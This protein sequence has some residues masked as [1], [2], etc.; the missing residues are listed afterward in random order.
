MRDANDM[1]K[2]QLGDIVNVKKWDIDNAIVIGV[3][4][5]SS[6]P[7]KH[8]FDCVSIEEYLNNQ[9]TYQYCLLYDSGSGI[10][11]EPEKDW[12]YESIID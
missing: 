4:Q 8:P 7:S 1:Q 5:V 6:I 11:C 9:D 10:I 3:E 2:Y 12:Y